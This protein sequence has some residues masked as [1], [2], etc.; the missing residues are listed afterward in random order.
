MVKCL[1]KRR[2]SPE[3]GRL[4]TLSAPAGDRDLDVGEETAVDDP[5]QDL[6]VEG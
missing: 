1:C 3:E 6:E 4:W 2:F 5:R